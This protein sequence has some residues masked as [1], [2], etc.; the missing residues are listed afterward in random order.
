M[1]FFKF[2]AIVLVNAPDNETPLKST[3]LENNVLD[4][5]QLAR[6]KNVFFTPLIGPLINNKLTQG[7]P[8][9]KEILKIDESHFPRLFVIDNQSGR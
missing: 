7:L 1:N 2:H 9:L 8:Q 4:A 5:Q 6:R 3:W